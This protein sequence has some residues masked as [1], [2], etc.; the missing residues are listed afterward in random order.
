MNMRRDNA[1]PVPDDVTLVLN[2]SKMIGVRP[3][4]T[5][6]TTKFSA[7]FERR[8]IS[9]AAKHSKMRESPIS[10]EMV[11]S[12]HVIQGPIPAA[13]STNIGEYAETARPKPVAPLKRFKS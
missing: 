8:A 9:M 7:L 6:T 13:T 3:E 1:P 4:T 2:T 11:L 12:V 5:A 10:Y